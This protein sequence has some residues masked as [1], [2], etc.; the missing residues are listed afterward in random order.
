LIGKGHHILEVGLENRTGRTE[1]VN[2]ALH[3]FEPDRLA[4]FDLE[5]PLAFDDQLPRVPITTKPPG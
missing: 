4:G 2:L 5:V 3:H 1:Q